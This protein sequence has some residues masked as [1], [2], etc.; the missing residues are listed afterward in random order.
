MIYAGILT[1]SSSQQLSA[2]QQDRIT[3]KISQQTL[4][5]V[6]HELPDGNDVHALLSAVGQL[7][8]AESHRPTAPYAPGVTGFA[9]SMYDRERL[10][11]VDSR[12][13]PTTARL[14]RALHAAIAH[15]LLT[16]Y[17]DRQA[18]NSTWMVLY[19]NRLLCPVFDLPLGQGGYREK[20]LTELIA[21][22][23]TGMPSS[24]RRTR[25]HD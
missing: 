8:K 22:V 5:R 13:D 24:L 21:W 16:P 18:K 19:M 25:L 12:Q 2:R 9:I 10:L 14:R 17:L 6:R 15:N 1:E 4:D 3:R 7:A 23:H 20:S 11:E